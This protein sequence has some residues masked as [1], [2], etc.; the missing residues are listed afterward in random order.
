[1][2]ETDISGLRLLEAHSGLDWAAEELDLTS[3]NTVAPHLTSTRSPQMHCSQNMQLC[4]AKLSTYMLSQSNSP[5]QCYL[6]L[7]PTQQL[8]H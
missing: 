2:G 1:M 3:S 6:G 5:T 7:H 8:P 4:A